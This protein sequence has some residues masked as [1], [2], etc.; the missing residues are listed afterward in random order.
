MKIHVPMFLGRNR[1]TAPHLMKDGEGQIAQN[2]RHARGDIRSWKDFNSTSEISDTT[3]YSFYYHDSESEWVVN[4]LFFTT[5]AEPP[6]EDDEW[7]R[8]YFTPYQNI[9]TGVHDGGNDQAALTDSGEDWAIDEHINKWVQNV[10]DGSKAK[11]TD[12]TDND[13]TAALAGG[14]ENLW[15]DGDVYYIYIGTSAGAKTGQPRF[16]ASD[17]LSATINLMTDSRLLGV[18][19][20]TAAITTL[21]PAVAGSSYRAYVYTYVNRYGQ[22]G[23]PSPVKEMT[24]YGSGNV[25]VTG[26]MEPPSKRGC[27]GDDG[28]NKATVR[29]YRTNDSDAETSA[30]QYV[31]SFNCTDVA[32]A[33]S[34]EAY[35][36]STG[37][38]DLGEVCP[39]TYWDPPPDDCEGLC[40]LSCGSMA[41]YVDNELWF[42]EPYYTHAWPSTYMLTFPHDIVSIGSFRNYVVVAT[43]GEPYI[44]YG[45]HPSDMIK[46]QLNVPYPCIHKRTISS[47]EDGVYYATYEG[48]V[49]VD[50]NGAR[51]ISEGLIEGYDW[52]GDY[53]NSM[54]T[55]HGIYHRGKYFLFYTD[56]S[57][58]YGGVILDLKKNT[59]TELVEY[60]DACWINKSTD[61]LYMIKE[62]STGSGTYSIFEWEGDDYNYMSYEWKSKLFQLDSPVNFSAAIVHTNPVWYTNYLAQVEGDN[63]IATQNAA[64]WAVGDLEGYIGGKELDYYSINHDTLLD[65]SGL[66]MSTNITFYLYGDNE[67]IF[68]KILDGTNPKPFKLPSGK[69]YHRYEFKVRGYIPVTS[70]TI[71]TSIS[72]LA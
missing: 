44:V 29:V 48:L 58:S 54:T 28:T 26:F 39:S 51:L 64:A 27:R 11:I 23:P 4:D 33:W 20:P 13:I 47:A 25:T 52:Y 34:A 16:L 18:P 22:E 53:F 72:E 56:G 68:T 1:K 12:N 63:Y 45:T 60:C 21:T 17:N 38:A 65:L 40:N 66:S 35:T 3:I 55:T 24:N 59:F 9:L 49:F 61:T 43:E 36:D 42:S 8:V 69:K 46:E 2:S 57:T 67:L 70:V 15:D 14:T 37:D 41:G 19:A 5:W 32:G 6:L 62:R 30:F 50:E 31:G 71:A 7:S 10:D